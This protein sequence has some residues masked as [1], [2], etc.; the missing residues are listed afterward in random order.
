MEVIRFGTASQRPPLLFV[1]GSYCGAWIWEKHFLPFFAEAGYAG[2]AISLTGHGKSAGAESIDRLGVAEF[3][4]DI[5]AGCALFD[6]PPVVVG[7]SLGGYLAQRFFLDKPQAGLVLLASPSLAGLAGSSQ[8]IL[9]HNPSLAWQLGLLMSFGPAFADA[10][11]IGNALFLKGMP[12]GE[13]EQMLPLLQRESSRVAIE[14]SWPCL[15]LPKEKKPTLIIG[16]DADAFVPLGDFQHEAL[17]WDGTLN[18]MKDVPH[19]LML[20]PCWPRVAAEVRTWLDATF[21]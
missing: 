18:I 10:E 7:H 5:A 14:A 21:A 3:L 2:A 20:D 12:E 11:A 4:A 15:T 19:G 13:K 6:R 8:H 17:F 16:G 9:F 1:H